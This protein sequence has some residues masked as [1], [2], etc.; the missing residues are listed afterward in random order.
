MENLEIISTG[1][2]CNALYMP[3]PLGREK[4]GYFLITDSSGLQPPIKG[5]KSAIGW[6]TDDS[7]FLSFLD[8]ESF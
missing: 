8:I 6:Y 1:G 4:Y 7:Q 2:G 5:E 3:H